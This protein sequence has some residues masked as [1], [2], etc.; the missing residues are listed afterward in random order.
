MASTNPDLITN[1]RSSPQAISP[2]IGF[3][4]FDLRPFWPPVATPSV[5]IGLIYLIIISFFSFSFY[6]PHHMKFLQTPGIRPLK[7]WHFIIWRLVATL[8]AYFF[9]SLAYS[10]ISLAFQ[11]NFTAPPGSHTELAQPATAYHHA[12]FVVYWMLNFVGM[13]A[14]GLACENV[15]M[16]IGQP[17]TASK[18]G[19]PSTCCLQSKL[20]TAISVAYILGH[21]QR[22]NLILLSRSSPSILLLGLCMAITQP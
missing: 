3:S 11:I 7:F 22:L 18:Q 15:A 21:Y 12:S 8:T 9:L 20:L 17:Y 5:S 1:L 14:L 2:A 19:P 4:T 6:L 16:F 10:W 13:A